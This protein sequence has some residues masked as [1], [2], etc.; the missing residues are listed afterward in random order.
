MPR[1][2]KQT[3]IKR[4]QAKILE[5]LQSQGLDTSGIKEP[6]LTDEEQLLE[7]QSV[8]NY[9]ENNKEGFY[10]E[11]CRGCGMKFAYSYHYKGIKS[12]SIECMAAQLRKIGIQWHYG[13]DLH[14]RWDRYYP[15]IVP[16]VVLELTEEE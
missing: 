9:F 11:K 10:Y 2:K 13:R 12:C 6:L 8:L 5:F 7:A 4:T 3:Q 16:G 15:A 1:L 14:D